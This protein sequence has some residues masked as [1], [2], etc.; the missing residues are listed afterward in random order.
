M[1]P[2][3]NQSRPDVTEANHPP[4]QIQPK[5]VWPQ[6]TPIQQQIVFQ[7]LVLMCHELLQQVSQTKPAEVQDEPD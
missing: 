3:I 2:V 5:Q 7:T 4:S 6:M 1:N